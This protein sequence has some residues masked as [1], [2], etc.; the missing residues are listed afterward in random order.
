M[1]SISRGLSKYYV[2]YS[3]YMANIDC[4]EKSSESF[5]IGPI[6]FTGSTGPT[7]AWGATGPVG[8]LGPLGP[9]GPTGAN[10][11]ISTDGIIFYPAPKPSIGLVKNYNPVTINRINENIFFW[12]INKFGRSN[13]IV[14]D[15]NDADIIKTDDAV[16]STVMINNIKYR[17]LVFTNTG[18]LLSFK[19]Q[20]PTTQGVFVNM[21]LIGGGGGGAR[22]TVLGSTSGAGAGNLIFMNNLLLPSSD[23][24]V[25]IGRGGKGANGTGNYVNGQK[26]EDS[27]VKNTFSNL[28][29]FTNYVAAGGAGA[30]ASST[31][32]N[33]QDGTTKSFVYYP[34]YKV[35]E[36]SSS[37]SGGVGSSTAIEN[38]GKGGTSGPNIS[39]SEANE[40]Y[41]GKTPII[42]S[43]GN[44]GGNSSRPSISGQ[45]NAG[46]G[47]GAYTSGDNGILDIGNSEANGNGGA[48]GKGFTIYY[49]DD[50]GQE[51]CGGSAGTGFNAL[52]PTKTYGA[53][54]SAYSGDLNPADKNA[55]DNS[56]SAG[57]SVIG[58]ASIAAG[59]GGSGIFMIRYRI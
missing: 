16:I 44:K 24:T 10:A 19:I 13:I 31:V 7:G 54:T 4:C 58:D 14:S 6:G 50:K 5:N 15:I 39:F 49:A 48:G 52:P 38:I 18:K 9:T 57:G 20:T 25:Y 17:I 46:G 43:Y 37:G 22:G 45:T 30:V 29:N 42:W 34:A 1:A 33:G 40:P 53:G 47:G 3:E 23:Y 8:A 21:C 35:G 55:L 36:T 56:G 27:Y 11:T 41:E 32:S 28:G 59:N 2:S 51:V 12:T 26:G